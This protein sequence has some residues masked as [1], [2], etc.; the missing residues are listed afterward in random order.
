MELRQVLRHALPHLFHELRHRTTP[1][2]P[3]SIDVIA[4]WKYS[5]ARCNAKWHSCR[6]VIIERCNKCGDGL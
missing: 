2:S 4:R 6:A 1:S 3:G 5:G